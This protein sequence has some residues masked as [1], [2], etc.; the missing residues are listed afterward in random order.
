MFRVLLTLKKDAS[1]KYISHLD[2]VKAFE[3]AL[4]RAKVPVAYSEGFNP[5]PR[6][7]FGT[8][9]GVGVCSD[10]ERFILDLAEPVEPGAIMD[11][12]N[13]NLPPGLRILSAES[14]PEGM[15]SPISGLNASDFE[16]TISCSDISAVRQVIV[17]ILG[18]AEYPVT[19]VKVAESKVVDIRPF[20]MSLDVTEIDNGFAVIRASFRSTNSGGGRPQD[21]IQAL[22]DTITDIRVVEIRRIRQYRATEDAQSL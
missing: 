17:R 7:S 10:D 6:M 20:V 22:C 14:V 2:L 5:R 3:C 16:I 12:L 1:V 15:K 21:I 4:R 13:G 11:S 8:A 9:V 18:S 19:R